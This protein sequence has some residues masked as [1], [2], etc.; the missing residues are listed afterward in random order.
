VEQ[1][2]LSGRRVSGT[3]LE[4]TY[5]HV[6]AAGEERTGEC[7]SEIGTGA[8]GRLLIRERWR[9]TCG[10]GSSGESEIEEIPA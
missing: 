7:R 1:G 8:E 4:F 10:D 5:R 2:R 6:N 9:W 3:E